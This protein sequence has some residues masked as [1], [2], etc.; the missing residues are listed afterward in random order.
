MRTSFLYIITMK[1]IEAVPNVSEGKNPI[2]LNALTDC[3]RTAPNVQLLGMDANPSANRTVFTLAGQPNAVC[4]LLF[5]FI[6]L[7]TRLIDMRTQRGAHPRLGAVDVC[8][9]VP[10]QEISLQETAQLAQSLGK[11]VG[12]ELQ[13]PV[14]LYEAAAA[15]AACNNLAFIR[16]GEY[17]NLA[18]K[19]HRLPPDFGPADFNEP[20]QKTGA[21]VI[22]ARNFLIAFN[23]N[24]NTRDAQIAKQIAARLRES[25]GGLKG[26]KAIGWYMEN[27]GRAQVSCNITDYHA[28]PL[29][30]VFETCQNHASALGVQATGCELVG[31]IPLEAILTAG[32]HYASAEENPAALIQAARKGLNLEE[33]KPFDSAEQILEFKAQPNNQKT[34]FY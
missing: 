13:I 20:V 29:H 5:D 22:G 24:L 18:E 11:R 27:F 28:A 4:N 7:A 3:L 32:K 30:L 16:R 23:I 31:L 9:L 1:W 17:E 19:L 33:V 14:Y 15:R 25:G 10:L 6:S 8:P 34:L 21:C 2:I 12:E 26:V